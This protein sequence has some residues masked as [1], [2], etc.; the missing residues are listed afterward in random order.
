MLTLYA[1]ELDVFTELEAPIVAQLARMLD[2]GLRAIDDARR[3]DLLA[4]VVEQS[5]NLVMIT[6]VDGRI[7]YVNARMTEV[8]GYELDEIIGQLPSL[9]RS[10]ATPDALYDE[11]WQTVLGGG[12]WRGEMENLAK[13]GRVYEAAMTVSPLL[14]ERGRTT[15]LVGTQE[16][17]TER[18]RM[19]RR[20]ERSARLESLGLLAGGVAHDF[21][22]LLGAMMMYAQQLVDELPAGGVPQADAAEIVKTAERAASLTR[23]LLAFSRRQMIAAA[24]VDLVMLVEDLARMLQRLLGASVELVVHRSEGQVHVRADRGQLE[25]VLIN[26][27]LNARD[28]MP[29]GGPLEIEVGQLALAGAGAAS[30]GVAAGSY[31]RLRVRDH[32]TGMSEATQRRIFEPFFSTKEAG[33]GTGLGLATSFGVVSQCGGTIVVQ[34]AL[35]EGSTFDVLLPASAPLPA[36]NEVGG[37]GAPG[38]T[39]ATGATGVTGELA[40]RPEGSGALVLL[41]DDEPA[42]RAVACRA[43]DRAGYRVV[44]ARDGEDALARFGAIADEVALLVTDVAMP[45]MDGPALAARLHAARPS[46]PVLFMSGRLDAELLRSP[47]VGATSGLLHKPF[48]PSELI[49]S[50]AAVVG[51]ARDASADGHPRE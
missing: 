28:A 27:C 51:E 35:G 43:L 15:R 9:L 2:S 4:R 14:D 19:K 26:L 25:Q 49:R 20:L 32:G 1:R 29:S 33:R 3:L 30:A 16:D 17:V 48:T 46:L 47:E 6:G 8:T 34:S 37:L 23:Q 10:P 50:V 11:L 12:T 39:G 36:A 31:G 7:E 5:S 24:D 41:V 38:V 44:T 42:L 18:N 40:P 22:N 13:S 45:R 21:N